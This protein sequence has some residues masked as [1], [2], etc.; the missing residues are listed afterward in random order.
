ME[1]GTWTDEDIA[2]IKARAKDSVIEEAKSMG[3]LELV[4]SSGEQKIK[5]LFMSFGFTDVILS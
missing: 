3:V 4:K 5:T 1:E 2:K